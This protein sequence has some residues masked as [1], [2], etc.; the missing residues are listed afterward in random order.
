MTGKRLI[1]FLVAALATA[2][3]AAPAQASIGIEAFETTSSDTQAGGHPDLTT[4]FTLEDPG[5]PGGGQERRLQ[6][7]GG[8]V[9]QPQRADALHRGGLRPD[10]M[11]AQ[12]AGRPDHDPRQLRRQ[13]RF[14][15]RHGAALRP[16]A[17]GRS[18][19]HASRSSSRPSTSRSRSRSR[20]GPPDRL[21]PA[22][23]RLRNHPADPAAL[24]DS[25]PSGAFPATPRTTRSASRRARP[26]NR[27]A[28]P[29]ST[30][31]SCGGTADAV[32]HPDPA[33]DRQPDDLHRRSAGHRLEVQSYQDL[34]HPESTPSPPIRR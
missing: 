14:P 11:P 23:H 31:A 2:A 17:A 9:R 13:R 3:L 34:E 28:A 4:S 26:A 21:R 12:L 5:Q 6:R 24:R 15:A 29:G 7:A 27:R 1:A 18:R 32:T 10:G 19:R 30:D 8:G 16:E 22:L 25:S 33:A 20:C